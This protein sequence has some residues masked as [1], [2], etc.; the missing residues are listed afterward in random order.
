MLPGIFVSIPYLRV[1]HLEPG[2]F[3]CSGGYV[4]IPYLRVT[5]QVQF[6]WGELEVTGFNPLST[7]H[8]PRVLPSA[9]CSRTRF[10]PLST[11]HALGYALGVAL[12]NISFNPLSTGHARKL[13]LNIVRIR[14]CFNPLSTGHALISQTSLAIEGLV[15]QSP[16][17]GSRT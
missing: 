13:W 17:Y 2:N 6:S 3:P 11:G 9:K 14:I 5:H 16:I 1:T 12:G 4:S 10:N 8:A 7:G 15:F